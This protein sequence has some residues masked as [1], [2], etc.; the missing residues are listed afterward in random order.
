LSINRFILDGVL[1]KEYLFHERRTLMKTTDDWIR[2]NLMVAGFFVAAVIL[3]TFM[4]CVVWF[5]MVANYTFNLSVLVPC[6]ITAALSTMVGYALH[7]WRKDNLDISIRNAGKIELT[8]L[9]AQIQEELES[10]KQK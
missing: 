7:G 2:H 10:R 9:A 3:N 8:V 5:I 6:G 1:E 4:W